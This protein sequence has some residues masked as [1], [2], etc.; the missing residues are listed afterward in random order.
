MVRFKDSNYKI[1][2][3]SPGKPITYSMAEAVDELTVFIDQGRI[4]LRFRSGR[5]EWQID[6]EVAEAKDL[7]AELHELAYLVSDS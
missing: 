1:K 6:L 5:N 4:R 3:S 7:A 2:K